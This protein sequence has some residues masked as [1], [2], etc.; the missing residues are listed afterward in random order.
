MTQREILDELKKMTPAERLKTIEAA[1]HLL[2]EELQLQ[3][4]PE[5]E[6]EKKH[7]LAAAAK[8]LLPDY[9][10]NTE[11]TAFTAL[12]SEDFHAQR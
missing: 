11:L 9:T 4:Q 6:A 5:A 8:A 12:D 2:H 1:L 10:T 7:R 3:E